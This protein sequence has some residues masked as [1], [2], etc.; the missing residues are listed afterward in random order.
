[1]LSAILMSRHA[2]GDTDANAWLWRQGFDKFKDDV[3][4]LKR[5]FDDGWS[6]VTRFIHAGVHNL[7][8]MF[9]NKQGQK[10]RLG[11]HL[12]MAYIVMAYIVM[13]RRCD[14]GPHRSLILAQGSL[15]HVD[16]LERRRKE[17]A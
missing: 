7:G 12:V 4:A 15:A 17:G 16:V 5:F 8:L 13:V 6:V 14:S 1:M 11:P 3:L 2:V 10:M 9:F